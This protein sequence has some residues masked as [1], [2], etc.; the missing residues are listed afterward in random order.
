MAM[1]VRE[2]EIDPSSEFSDIRR[3]AGKE[4]EGGNVVRHIT[5]SPDT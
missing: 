4:I 1:M 3:S 2:S 5:K